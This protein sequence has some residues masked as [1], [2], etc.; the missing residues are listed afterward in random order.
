MIKHLFLTFCFLLLT[1]SA[2]AA[3][4]GADTVARANSLRKALP[5]YISCAL[6]GNDDE[7]QLY[8]AQI[9]ETGKGDVPKNTQRALLFYHL[10]SENGNASAM[11]GLSKLLTRLDSNDRSRAEIPLYLEK[12]QSSLAG[13]LGQS[14]RG[15]LLHP[16]TLLLLASEKQS[17]K[18]F[19][20]TATKSD[21]SATQLLKSYKID[22]IKKK[23]C[24]K[25]A[26]QWKQRRMMDIAR[27]VFSIREYNDFYDIL[28]PDIGL[29]D[30][31]AREQAVNR[32]KERV[33]R[34]LS[35]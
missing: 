21:S 14:F 20:P 27:E 5:I 19:Y 31:F 10:G 3:C 26:S 22:P 34:K 4:P 9:Y 6:Q 8:L 24:L 1:L 32:L 18:W 30:P 15:Q 13:N 23:A 28:Y 25:E 35:K 29:P 16:Y 33:E 11:V 17:A 2:H 7:T 12:I